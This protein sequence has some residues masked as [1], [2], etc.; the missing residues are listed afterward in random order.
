MNA[1]LARLEAVEA[2]LRALQREVEELRALAGAAEPEPEPEPEPAPPAYEYVPPAPRAPRPR[3]PRPTI[4]AADLMS[5]RTLASAGG[6]VTLLGVVLLFVLAVNRGWIGPVERVAFGAVA[7]AVAVALG[8]VVRSRYGQYH[9]ALAAVGAGIGGGYATLLA[10]VVLYDLVPQPVALAIAAAIAA[11]GVVISLLWNAQLVAALGLVGATLAPAAVALDSGLS[12]GGVA[13][14]AFVFAGTAVV[15]IERGWRPLLIAGVVASLPQ[16]AALA[17]SEPDSVGG[18]L[19]VTLG[20]AALYLAAGLATQLR[21]GRPDRPAAAL[22]LLSATLSF[23]SA[24][25]LLEGTA[26]NAAL[27][28]IAGVYSLLTA[29]IFA[30]DRELAAVVAVA[31]LTLGAFA[32]ANVLDGPSLVAVWSAEAAGLAWL[33]GRV[34]DLRYTVGALAYLALAAGHALFLDAPGDR[35][36]TEHPDPAAG[37]PALV[38]A[39]LAAVLVAGA[40]RRWQEEEGRLAWLAAIR[41]PLAAGLV[42]GAAVFGAY[43]AALGLVELVGDFDWGHLGVIALWAVAGAV[44][45]VLGGRLGRVDLLLGGALWLGAVT[46]QVVLFAL[47]TLEHPARGWATLALAVPALAAGYLVEL[48][49]PRSVVAGILPPLSAIL[50]AVAAVELAPSGDPTGYSLLGAAAAYGVLTAPVFVRSRL[51]ATQLWAIAVAFALAASVL[52]LDGTALAAAWAGAA[53]G[54]ALL[55]YLF[56]EGRFQLAALGYAAL[57]LGYAVVVLAPPNELFV[58]NADPANGAPA[59]FLAAVAALAV[60]LLAGPVRLLTLDELDARLR[61]TQGS[62]RTGAA[63]TAGLTAFYGLSLTVLGIVA[64]LGGADLDTEFQRGH[65]TVSSVWG[66]IGLV[67]LYLGLRYDWRA[68]RPAGFG[69]FAVSLAKIFLFDLS[70]LSSIAR[71]VSFL[72]VGALLLTAGFFYQRLSRA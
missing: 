21:S 41:A 61:A 3:R 67:L 42:W 38:A 56:R 5:A 28:A 55:A 43:T 70:Q 11:V 64:W 17:G 71:A 25:A 47:P 44:I 48:L 15:A 8:F 60:A 52:L 36:Y 45:L 57:A 13:F 4:N 35:L 65:T 27:L 23:A 34:R 62:L 40:S 33:A 69:L 49:E 72:A 16:A 12:V 31:A 6:V 30:R 9:S 20:F 59:V 58:A 46:V 18:A 1:I 14:A 32:L 22:V 53:A 63:W 66:A 7:S 37:I 10:A 68:F 29:A 51:L 50:G 19:G 39:L 26:E 24:A 2:Q 54:L